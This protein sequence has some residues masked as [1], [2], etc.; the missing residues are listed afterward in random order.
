MRNRRPARC[1][2]GPLAFVDMDAMAEDR[3][4]S[5]DA[6]F[7]IHLRV[8][9]ARG[10]HM[11]HA[12][13]F[14]ARLGEMRLDVAAKLRGHR[15]GFAHEPFAAREGKARTERV[16]EQP[17]GGTVPFARETLAFEHGNAD[18]L[19]RLER[20]VSAHIHHHFPHNDTQPRARRRRKRRIARILVNR[21]V[22]H[23]RRRAV[24]RQ[25]GE[26]RS[27]LALS[28]RAGESPFTRKNARVQPVEK[29]PAPAR[30]SRVLRDVRMQIDQA[31]ENDR[32]LRV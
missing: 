27:R 12:F 1:Q 13:A 21:R 22:K 5:C 11:A 14:L 10:E 23:R 7:F 17:L 30:H 31:G 15:S 26:K 4:R 16:F 3:A 29:L 9:A 19:A 24:T 25:F 18:D 2:R 8:V 28:G 32:A 20:P 6:K